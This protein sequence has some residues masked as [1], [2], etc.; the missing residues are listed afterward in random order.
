[1]K[2]FW[3]RL[4]N[5]YYQRHL[6]RNDLPSPLRDYLH[7][8]AKLDVKKSI[9]DTDFVI[10]DTETT[11]FNAK[12]GDRIVSISAVRLKKGRIDLSDAFH[13]LVN[14]NRDIPSEAAVVHEILPRM[15]NGKPGIESI[16]PDFLRYVGT[17]CAGC[18]SRLA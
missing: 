9:A 7:G 13:A 1:M 12:K 4:K 14:P 5:R 18:P 16:L 2:L 3:I 6:R 17:A 11:G 8:F 15:V 10:F